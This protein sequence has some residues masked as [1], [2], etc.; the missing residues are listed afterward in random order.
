MKIIDVSNPE[1]IDKNPVRIMIL[2]SNG[3]T[4]QNGFKIKTLELRLYTNVIQNNTSPCSIITAY[5]ETDEHSIESLYDEGSLEDNALEKSTE[6]LR[7]SLGLSGLILRL[8]I[9]LENQLKMH[10]DQ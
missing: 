10:N 1:Y 6:L 9:S 8:I 4:I 7:N 5:L 3:E 2:L